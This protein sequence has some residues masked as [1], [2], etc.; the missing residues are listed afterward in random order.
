MPSVSLDSTPDLGDQVSLQDNL[1]Q[2][3]A[4]SGLEAV[5]GDLLLQT[6][7]DDEDKK[8][9]DEHFYELELNLQRAVQD[10][11]CDL[12]IFGKNVEARLEEAT[13]QV[14]PV[15]EVIAALQQENLR[16]RIQQEKLVRQVMAL[17][18]A[19]GLPEPKLTQEQD[20]DPANANPSD[21][22]VNPLLHPPTFAAVCHASPVSSPPASIS[23]KNSMVL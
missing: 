14:A 4:E 10:V 19:I 22:E 13:A 12:K 6:I 5:I 8:A 21:G 1:D 18:D 2:D 7:A 3:C 20:V 23:R 9:T 15:I 16:L 17:C 11:H